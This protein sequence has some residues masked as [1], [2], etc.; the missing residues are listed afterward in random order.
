METGN[1]SPYKLGYL[2]LSLH[3]NPIQVESLYYYYEDTVLAF[4]F[5]LICRSQLDMWSKSF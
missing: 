4:L 5:A 2:F 3:D 1:N